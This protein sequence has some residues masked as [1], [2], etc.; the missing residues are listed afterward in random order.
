MNRY[1]S[2]QYSNTNFSYA[3]PASSSSSSSK[4]AIGSSQG[5]AS[6]SSRR[7]NLNPNQAG[8]MTSNEYLM[9][10]GRY[11]SSRYKSTY[12]PTL[13]HAKSS[14]SNRLHTNTSYKP[15]QLPW[16]S[17]LASSSRYPKVPSS[18]SATNAT[19]ANDVSGGLPSKRYTASYGKAAA[20]ISSTISGRSLF[21]YSSPRTAI[22]TP[23]SRIYDGQLRRT[24]TARYTRAPPTDPIAS[25]ISSSSGSSSSTLCSSRRESTSKL[26]G[27]LNETK[28]SEATPTKETGK[29]AHNKQVEPKLVNPE[30]SKQPEDN[31]PSK[32]D[33]AS[34]V[35]A[36]EDSS[37]KSSSS[38]TKPFRSHS[39]KLRTSYS[40]ILDQLSKLR[41]GSSSSSS[42]SS[43]NSLTKN[44]SDTKSSAVVQQN[45]ISR[46]V[47]P[48]LEMVPDE[49]E[50][51]HEE[52]EAE[53]EETQRVISLTH[54]HPTQ[55]ATRPALMMAS[56]SGDSS[57]SSSSSGLSSPGIGCNGGGS[58][59][60]NCNASSSTYSLFSSYQV[61]RSPVHSHS[62]NKSQQ[63]DSGHSNDGS[64]VGSSNG[65]AAAEEEAQQS[66]PSSL[67]DDDADEDDASK[68]DTLVS[69]VNR[70][71]SYLDKQLGAERINLACRDNLATTG[72][73]LAELEKFDED[74]SDQLS[75]NHTAKSDDEELDK[76][77]DIGTISS[78]HPKM[79]C[80][81]SE[82]ILRPK[83]HAL[84]S[85]SNEIS[86]LS[87]SFEWYNEQQARPKQSLI[88]GASHRLVEE[89]D[90]DEE[91]DEDDEEGEEEQQEKANRATVDTSL[92]SCVCFESVVC[93]SS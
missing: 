67:S 28:T 9:T 58:G 1:M 37:T 24:V 17:S 47:R 45:S 70:R 36:T 86:A 41:L 93:H 38:F 72:A 85:S 68:E 43:N 51:E 35:K 7:A 57:S 84:V 44:S 42:T 18:S 81:E 89:E 20:A 48:V 71:L 66:T 12:E 40:N 80:N 79:Q 92:V 50:S 61:A 14:P 30:A 77:V 25:S 75:L 91:E 15:S 19:R 74:S 60:G 31:K 3:A 11:G 2:Y 53:E 63:H 73:I 62:I 56:S 33:A 78:N 54:G 88:H 27:S 76:V 46:A 32:L 55:T 34:R 22:N 29:E 59:T 4:V 39:L 6:A 82:L 23:A 10:N 65:Q 83:A 90:D 69:P 13:A 49:P 21:D 26:N 5:G 52:A 87:A 64:L 16:S 8:S